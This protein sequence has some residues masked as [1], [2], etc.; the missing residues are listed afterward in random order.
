[1]RITRFSN[2]LHQVGSKSKAWKTEKK[3]LATK[4]QWHK[5]DSQNLLNLRKESHSFI[6]NYIHQA[7][8]FFAESLAGNKN[9]YI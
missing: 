3:K 1:V 9:A 2:N 5:Q 4:S 6:N 7:M 8:F